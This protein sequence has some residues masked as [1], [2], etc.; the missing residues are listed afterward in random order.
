[1]T[2]VWNTASDSPVAQR[3]PWD[4]FVVGAGQAS[5]VLPGLARVS[6]HGLKHDLQVKKA[7]GNDGATVTDTGLELARFTVTLTLSCQE[8][9]DEFIRIVPKLQ[10]KRLN[11]GTGKME[12]Q[13]IAVAHP[14]LE[15]L[16]ITSAKL[17]RVGIARPGHV[18]GTYEADLEFLEH[19]PP[20]KM[21][22]R[23]T[24]HNVVDLDPS[25]SVPRK[26]LRDKTPP[27]IDTGP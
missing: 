7:A 26:S 10:P 19:Q 24:G 1:M 13:P 11:A 25:A 16:Q 12:L 9:W 21:S 15:P 14:A 2:A 3:S 17:E 20:K 8:D 23:G 18:V 22:A 6:G 4:C 27:K 5:V